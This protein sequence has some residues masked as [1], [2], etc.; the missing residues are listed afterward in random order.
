[1]IPKTLGSSIDPLQW[2]ERS[3]WTTCSLEMLEPSIVQFH[4]SL[5]LQDGSQLCGNVREY[6]ENHTHCKGSISPGSYVIANMQTGGTD[7]I[8]CKLLFGPL[9]I[10]LAQS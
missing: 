4:Y 3:A 10:I 5:V 8:A 1:M 9:G 2:V 6:M 7:L